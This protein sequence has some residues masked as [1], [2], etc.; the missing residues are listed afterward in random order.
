MSNHVPPDELHDRAWEL[1]PW[2]V[3]GRLVRDEE[4]WVASAS[5]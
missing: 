2:I 3:N 4:P 1:L 5:R